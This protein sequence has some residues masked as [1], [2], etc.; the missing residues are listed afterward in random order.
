[1]YQLIGAASKQL[2]PVDTCT[3]C[4][5]LDETRNITM[6]K[7]DQVDHLCRCLNY[8]EHGSSLVVYFPDEKKSRCI[9]SWTKAPAL[10]A[11]LWS[12]V[13]IIFLYA[14]VH[15]LYIVVV[16]CKH[17]RCTKNNT[18]ALFVALSALCQFTS[19]MLVLVMQDYN[20]VSVNPTAGDY[21]AIDGIL[22]VLN[23]CA[24][25]C[26]GVFY[27]LLCWSISEM[28]F[29]YE[30]MASRRRC[31]NFV[32]WILIIVYI[33]MY[34][35]NIFTPDIVKVSGA[36]I[37]SESIGTLSL[38]FIFSSRGTAALMFVIPTV[39]IVLAHRKMRKV[40]LLLGCVCTGIH[41]C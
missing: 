32:F 30:D 26:S 14:A 18:S 16:S 27:A 7:C 20:G 22:K 10:Y 35:C 21:D 40:S 9:D 13:A 31:V 34:I 19:T 11:F 37:T 2:F 25:V 4:A 39:L 28:V 6:A 1:M 41:V 29:H 17:H 3:A 15:S 5:T 23:T 33:L 8:P 24:K 36:N 38:L 12:T